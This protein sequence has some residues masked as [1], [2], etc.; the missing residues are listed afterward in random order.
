MIRL[1]LITYTYTMYT[2]H[3]VHM[4]TYINDFTN[5]FLLRK[6]FAYIMSSMVYVA[7]ELCNIIT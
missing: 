5:D 4:R 6:I 3:V 1:S 7:Y 2:L